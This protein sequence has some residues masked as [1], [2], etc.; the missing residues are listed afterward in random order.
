MKN[1]RDTDK[2][3]A[4]AVWNTLEPYLK[5][6]GWLTICGAMGTTAYA[7]ISFI[8]QGNVSA[9]TLSD[10]RKFKSDTQTSI[11]AIT[12]QE[13]DT[14]DKVNLIY[15]VLIRGGHSHDHQ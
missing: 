15:G 9:D 14:N 4:K 5:T 3:L 6:G 7:I 1:R 8:I 11:A 2:C 12:V 13:K 10:Y